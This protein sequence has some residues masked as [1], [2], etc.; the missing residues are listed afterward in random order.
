M[1]SITI[2][3]IFIGWNRDPLFLSESKEFALVQEKL[4]LFELLPI[5]SP[6]IGQVDLD[7][8]R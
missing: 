3:I 7:Y 8:H 1:M 5:G 4:E 6:V 2:R